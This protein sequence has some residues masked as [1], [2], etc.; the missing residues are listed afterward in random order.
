MAVNREK[1]VV[2]RFP[3][4]NLQGIICFSYAGASP[5]LMGACTERELGLTFCT[6]RGKF[7]VRASGI[8]RGNVLLRRSQYRL[9]DD[10]MENCKIARNMIFGKVYNA[11][12]SVERT[13]RDHKMRRY[14]SETERKLLFSWA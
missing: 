8:S 13:R 12:W 10:P 11:R 3:L 4:H 7:L 1:T 14:D 9:A 6:P 2:A 5:A